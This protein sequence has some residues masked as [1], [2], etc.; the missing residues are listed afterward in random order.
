M[1]LEWIWSTPRVVFSQDSKA[2]IYTHASQTQ[3]LAIIASES[4]GGKKITN[5]ACG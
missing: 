3:L 4:E 5:R 2:S 1:A